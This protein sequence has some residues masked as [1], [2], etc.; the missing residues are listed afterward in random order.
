MDMITAGKRPA[1]RPRKRWID[2]VKDDLQLLVAW[3]EWQQTANNRKEWRTL[4]ITSSLRSHNRS[5]GFDRGVV[6]VV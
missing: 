6:V 5:T 3:E 2:G 1:G 4:V